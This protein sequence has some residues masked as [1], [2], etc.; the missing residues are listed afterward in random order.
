MA[1]RQTY[2]IGALG[3]LVGMVVGANSAQNAQTVSFSGANYRAAQEQGMPHRAAGYLRRRSDEQ[4][5]TAFDHVVDRVTA[6][7]RT[8]L[9]DNV[10]RRYEL[11]LGNLHN[12]APVRT[13]RGRPIQNDL[14]EGNCQGQIVSGR[15]Y[16]NCT[17]FDGYELN[18]GF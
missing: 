15:R 17:Y 7:R 1:S 9:E 5:A 10:A 4:P 6:P 18:D 2:V 12:A 14:S 11:R 8:S 16:I 13:V 3:V